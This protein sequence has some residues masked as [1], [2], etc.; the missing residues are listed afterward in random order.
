MRVRAG[1]PRKKNPESPA[2]I[3]YIHASCGLPLRKLGSADG[4][5]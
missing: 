4:E 1:K 5:I 3:L 2:T